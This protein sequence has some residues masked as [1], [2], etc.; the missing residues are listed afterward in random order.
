MHKIHTTGAVWVTF[1]LEA[2]RSFP[3]VTPFT[4]YQLQWVSTDMRGREESHKPIVFMCSCAYIHEVGQPLHRQWRGG[5]AV[6]CPGALG[7]SPEFFKG[8]PIVAHQAA[9]TPGFMQGN[10][11]KTRDLIYCHMHNARGYTASCYTTL[12]PCLLRNSANMRQV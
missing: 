9:Q 8:H 2:K 7:K 4:Q 5:G 10:S 3:P 11:E 6:R 1:I 12:A